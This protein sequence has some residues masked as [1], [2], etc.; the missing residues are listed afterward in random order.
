MK[1]KESHSKAP[2][3]EALMKYKKARVVPFDVPGHK[4]G[5]GNPMLKEFLGEQCLSVDVNSMK[6]LDNLCHPVSVIK[7]AECLAAD[8]FGSK[9]AFF[10]VN[11][12]TSAVQAMVMSVCKRDE[13]VIMP[14]NVHR[15]AINALVISGAIPVYIDPGVNKKLGI[16]LGMSVEDVKIAIKKN[17]DAKAVLVNNP[18]YYGI[19]S[20]L[21]E[22]TKLAH[23]H[24]MYVLVDEAHGTHFYFGEDM[25]ISAIEAG[26]DMAAVSM[27]KTGGSLTQSSFLLLN[28]DLR[29]GYVRQIINLTQ[30]TSGSYLLMSSL[31]LARRDLVLNGKEIFEKV[32]NLAQYARDEINKINGYYAFSEELI[33]KDTVF[34]FDRTKLA[35]FTRDI[36]LAGIEVYDILRDEY[37]IQIELGDIANILAIISVGDG[38]L[39]I[40]RLISALSEIKR[41]HS[42]DKSG[43]FDHEYINPEVILTPQEAFYSSKVSMPINE[44][45]GNV[46]AEFVMC[47]P[48]GIP[49]LAPGEKIT[50]E[51]LN[52][53]SYAKEKG[54]FL[55]GTEDAKIENINVVEAD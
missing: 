14:R 17:P 24:G 54:C 1:D 5:R 53:I 13:K 49:I 40:E 6:P 8:A 35:I 50:K 18:T 47:Y 41:L 51:I 55:T 39:T 20:N 7:E 45:T 22:I 3:Y 37:G 29:V 43:M 9:H 44:S 48:P 15:S 25:P 38:A 26:A 27:H 28:C 19:C 31:D 32:K 42:K 21:K 4:Q 11:G 52:Y 10:M 23:E 2:I 36:G 12:T 16:P 34:D 30:T 33:D 46:C